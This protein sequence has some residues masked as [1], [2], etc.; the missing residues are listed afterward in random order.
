MT[1]RF[2]LS[3]RAFLGGAAATIS[4]PFLEAMLP[5]GSKAYAQQDVPRRMLCYYVPNGFHMPSFTPVDEGANFTLSETLQPLAALQ[6]DILVLTGLENEA[7]N[8]DG[9]GDHAAGTGS[10]LTAYHV[11]KTEG[12]DIENAISVDQR[13]ANA[14]GEATRYPSLQVGMDGGGSTGNCDSGYSC[15]YARNVSWAGPQTPLPK[16]VDPQVIFDRLFAGFDPEATQ[17]EREKRQR[18][19]QSILDY[20][21]E[22]ANKL[23]DKLGAG[24]RQKLEEYLT[25]IRELET[26]IGDLD[27]ATLCGVPD[28]PGGSYNVT[29]KAQVM[30]DLMVLAF[31][32]DL[33][34]IQSF[35]LSNAGSG[36]RYDFLGISEGH[37]QISHHQSLQENYDK[38]KIINRWEVEQFAYLVQKLKDTTDGNGDPLLDSTTVFLSSEISDGNRH[39]HD[40]LP[41]IIAGQG[42]GTFNTGRHVRYNDD[43]IA[44]LFISMLDAVGVE[45]DTFGMDGSGP[46]PNI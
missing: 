30:S 14:I 43:P 42:G 27:D 19:Q 11:K 16:T 37:H 21:I 36:R 46:L 28:R 24:D 34:R 25:G 29:E 23:Q 17:E 5:I 2:R 3:R 1:K 18:Y 20:A 9:P 45:A 7:A 38:L 13:A 10:F 32:C 39:N 8:P 31:Q 26:R 33:T 35:M 15:A 4:L 44:N 22:D 40:D 41:V 6:D 12:S